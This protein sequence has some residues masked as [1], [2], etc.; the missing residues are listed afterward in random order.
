[1]LVAPS[2]ERLRER[3]EVARATLDDRL[4]RAPIRDRRPF[5]GPLLVH[6]VRVRV[7]LRVRVRVGLGQG[8]G[9]G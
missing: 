9:Q 7:R 3:D 2:Y 1:M 6:L 8:T 5:L 4:A